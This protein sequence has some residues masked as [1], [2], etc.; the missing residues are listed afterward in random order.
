VTLELGKLA[1]QVGAMGQELAD[2]EQERAKLVVL[3]QGWL[4]Q[5]ADQNDSLRHPARNFRA[6]IPTGELLNATHPLPAVPER[7]TFIAAD[8]SEIQPDSHT[9]ALYY[10]IN[11]GGM[12]YRHGSGQ[13][14]EAHS[15]PTIG[16]TDDE[17][18]EN[19]QPVTG[20]L[21][22]VKRDIA[23][24]ECLA[25]L[26]V[27]EPPD[28]TTVAVVDG[29]LVLWTLKDTPPADQARRV[30]DYL[31]QLDRIR[32]T[33]AS[34]A[35]FISRP[36]RGEVARL[37]HLANVGGDVKRANEEPSPLQ[38]LPD[39]AIFASLPPGARSALFVSPSAINHEHYSP[40]HTIHFFY[41]NLA[42]EG[43]E[44][45]VARIEVPAWVAADAG[46]LAI[47]HGTIVTQARVTGDYPYALVRADELAFISGPEREAFED[48]IASSL[49][50]AGVRATLSPKRYYKTLTRGG[51]RKHKR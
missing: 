45:A 46:R 21:L 16:Y 4:A 44:P 18:Y 15:Q 10:L 29:T 2:R 26:C 1:K 14:P 17:I 9:V 31:Q 50:R 24:I 27:A 23:E 48:M 22:D 6:A 34:V 32:E 3:A 47:V 42:A 30:S 13:A 37:L 19:G 38:H 11:I 51:K 40:D 5:Y 8:G 33:G 41:L 49:V 39:H 7:F 12:V 43:N 20:N 28:A 36:Q 35:A 25:D